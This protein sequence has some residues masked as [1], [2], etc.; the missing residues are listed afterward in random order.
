MSI[1]SLN[2]RKKTEVKRPVGVNK[3]VSNVHR[4]KSLTS[5]K[6]SQLKTKHLK[7]RTFSKMGCKS[8]Q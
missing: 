5:T 8:I 4:F 2:L 3:T 7:K 6:L 1:F